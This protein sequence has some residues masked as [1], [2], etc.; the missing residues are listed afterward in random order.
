MTLP[1][2]LPNDLPDHPGLRFPPPLIFVIATAFGV[3][4]HW[5]RPVAARPDG[6]WM[7]GA[8]ITAMALILVSWAA[9]VLRR[10][11]TAVY[12][13]R[14]TTAIVTSGPYAVSRN[15]IYLGFALL[16]LGLGLWTDR[17]AVVLMVIPAIAA[18]NAFV[19][20]REEAY[21]ER[22]FGETYAGYA[23]RVRRW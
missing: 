15:P 9:H 10:H 4:V 12:P 23:R 8:A 19:I 6:W 3:F 2:S 11:Q 21:L 18:T 14:P 7:F 16:Q 17:L 22:K 5:L 1:K 20:A 13:W